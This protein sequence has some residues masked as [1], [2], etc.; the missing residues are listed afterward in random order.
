MC[1][2]EHSKTCE[3]TRAQIRL[4]LLTLN[5]PFSRPKAPHNPGS[6]ARIQ[7]ISHHLTSTEAA[8]AHICTF[9]FMHGASWW[10][11]ATL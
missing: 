5:N 1:V 3:G 9:M 6:W 10:P 4:Q 7:Q 8:P 11:Q 2:Q